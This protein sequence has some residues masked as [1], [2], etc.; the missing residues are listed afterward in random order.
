MNE[1][2]WFRMKVSVF[3]LGKLLEKEKID[4]YKLNEFNNKMF[5]KLKFYI[6]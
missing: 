3:V 4:I 5:L 6:L 2:G 1:D